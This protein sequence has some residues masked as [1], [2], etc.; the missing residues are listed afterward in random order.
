MDKIDRYSRSRLIFKENFEKLQKTKVLVCG[1]GGVG[2][3]AI[4]ALYRSGLKN[5]TIIDRDKFEI[6]NQNRQLLSENLGQYKALAFEEKYPGIEALVLNIDDYFISSFDFSSFDFVI[7]AIDDVDAK[8]LLAKRLA[9]KKNLQPCFFSS[10]G[11]AKRI[12]PSQILVDDI[13]KTSNDALAKKIRNLLKKDRFKGNFKVVYSKEEPLCK[14]LGSCITVTA[15][16]GLTL[17]SLVLQE[18]FKK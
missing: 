2:G 12:D 1:C 13:F 17:A 18:L 8:I 7:D 11:A 3:A 10:M 6:T 5:L 15:S 9:Y 14:E 4:D 16:F